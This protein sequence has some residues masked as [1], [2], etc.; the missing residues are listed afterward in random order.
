[1]QGSIPGLLLSSMTSYHL[2]TELQGTAKC[3]KVWDS[4][5]F[6]QVFFATPPLTS[7][8]K[9]GT[10]VATLPG[11]WCYKISWPSCRDKN[12]TK[13]N[14]QTRTQPPQPHHHRH[15]HTH[16][17][18]HTHIHTHTHT[19]AHAHAHTHTHTELTLQRQE[20]GR[21][22][23]GVPTFKSLWWLDAGKSA[24]CKRESNSGSSALE[25]DAWT[26][27]PTR[28][29]GSKQSNTWEDQLHR[30]CWRRLVSWLAA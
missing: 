17:H 19:H 9:T 11:A 6:E 7:G 20:P 28:Q 2:A 30:G 8:L 29:S 22:A 16:T 5:R 10:L 26:T 24:Q 12:K 21:V 14:Q 25:A 3:K 27:R 18:T 15:Q 4:K 1:M 13:E 23:T